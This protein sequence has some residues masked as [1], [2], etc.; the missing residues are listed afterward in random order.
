MALIYCPECGH[1]ISTAAVA[2]PN[3]GRPIQQEKPVI[4]RKVV[5]ADTPRDSDGFPKWAL[6]PLGVL[7][8]VLLF[9]LFVA[10]SRDNDDSNT[11]LAVNVST[12]RPANRDVADV[13]DSRTVTAPDSTID[14][15]TVNVPGSQTTGVNPPAPDKGT[16]VI[17][18]KIAT[19][20][21]SPQAVR[22]ERFYL[23]DKDLESILDDAG[24]EPIEG[25]SLVNS[26]GLSVLY[27]DRFGEFNRNALRAIKEHIKYAGQ[28][29]G[30]GKAQLAGVEPDSYYLF[31]VTKAGRGFAVWSAPVSIRAGENIMNLT[32]QRVTEM[33]TS[34]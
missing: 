25:Q 34:G 5:V 23:L 4:E 27:P 21:G 20:T 7:G 26:L 2:C 19:R 1:E 16:V 14:S 17:E 33:D 12:R 30:T 3:C 11:N 29:D 22:N 6:I 10:L 24:L 28:T 9:I 15:Q 13:P 8:A 18:A 31:G 32:P